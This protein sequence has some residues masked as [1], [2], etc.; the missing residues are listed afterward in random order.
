[1]SYDLHP[2]TSQAV[3]GDVFIDQSSASSRGDFAGMFSVAP[4]LDVTDRHCR[5]LLRL[6]SRRMM[7]YTEMK[8]SGAILHGERARFLGFDERER[9]L[10]IQL[11]GSQPAALAQCARLAE[12]AGYDEVNLNVGCPSARVKNGS[13]GACLMAQPELV[14]QCVAAMRDAVAIP[15]T[16]K[17][18]IGIDHMDS[19]QHLAAFVARVSE[20][21]CAHFIVHARK[22]WLRGLSPKQ[23]RL[24]P[25]LNYPRVYRLRRDFPALRFTINGGIDTLSQAQAHLRRVDG[26]M[27]GRAAYQNP[28]LL[29]EVDAQIFRAAAAPSPPSRAAVVAAYLPYVEQQLAGGVYLRHMTRHLLGLYHGQL[30]AKIWRRHLAEHGAKKGAGVEVITAALRLVEGQSEDQSESDDGGDFSMRMVMSADGGGRNTAASSAVVTR[31][32]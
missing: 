19:Y 11:G 31:A 22:A 20:G 13:F 2:M 28:W 12:E 15:I 14:A 26:V 16:V 10:A 27:L 9:P 23:N 4:M 8:V 30:R 32:T 25:P 3:A 29:R 18:R 6:L 17:T 24:L 7:L 5:M 1:M 21:G